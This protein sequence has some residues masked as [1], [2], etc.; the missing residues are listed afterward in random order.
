MSR[1]SDYDGDEQFNNQGELWY[2]NTQ[3]ALKGKRGR[4]VLADMREALLALPQPRLIGGAL[5]TVGAERRTEP[6]TDWYREEFLRHAGRQ[7][8]G[9]CAIGAYLWHRKVKAGADP[10]EAFDSLPLVFG[11]DDEDGLDLTAREAKAAGVAFCLAWDLAYRN[12]E[13]LG[14]CTPEER[15]ARFLAW[16]DR[17]LGDRE[18]GHA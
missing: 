9:V 6:M 7:G 3:R 17:E 12:D 10:A 11:S 4:K 13:M 8:E 1:F 15:H 14:D 2:A 18:A 5:S 16:I